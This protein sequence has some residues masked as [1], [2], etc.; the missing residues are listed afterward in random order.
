MNNQ[1]TKICEYCGTSFNIIKSRA[2]TAKYC[3]RKCSNQMMKIKSKEKTKDNSICPIC[4]KSFYVKKSQIAKT[5]NCCS[6]KCL[7]EHRK[8]IY[9]GNN[10]PNY[11]GRQEDKDGYA[12]KHIPSIG[13]VKLHIYLACSTLN[14]DKIPKGYHVHHRDCNKL[15]NDLNNLV[16]LLQ[17]DHQWL[18]KQFGSAGLWAYYNNKLSLE[19]AILW[20][21]DKEKCERLLQLNIL[22]QK[23]IGVFKS[24][25]LLESPE[26]DNQQPS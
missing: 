13:R 1:I 22:K 19:N 9:L 12:I 20:S 14:I 26:E 6:Y 10:N 21:N 17:E 23:E 4:N 25:E 18:H 3:C 11:K 2:N 16:V 7:K 5:G 24:D 8:L 15:N